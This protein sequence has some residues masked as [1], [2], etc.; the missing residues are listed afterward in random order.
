MIRKIKACL[1]ALLA[2]MLLPCAALAEDTYAIEVDITNQIVTIYHKEDR[3]EGGVVRQMICSTGSGEIPE[4]AT[5]Q[6]EFELNQRYPNERSEWY[7]I[8]KY[9]CYVQYVTRI[10]DAYLFHSLP[11]A[12]KDLDTLD[13][14]AAANLGEPVSHGCIRLRPEDAKWI[15]DNC[16]NGTYVRIFE[17][18]ERNELLR[19][20]LKRETYSNEDHWFSYADF[21]A[22]AGGLTAAVE[23]QR[24]R[25]EIMGTMVEVTPMPATA[26]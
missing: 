25:T 16:P 11:Y 9:N 17:S 26:E 23:A 7:A 13:L 8:P 6:G 2:L 3:T 4:D 10:I 22:S 18:G 5:P 1:A 19:D 15:S 21:I 24:I 12:E 20:L 14:E